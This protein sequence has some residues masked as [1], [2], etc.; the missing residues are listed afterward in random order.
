M[1]QFTWPHPGEIL[2]EEF[3]EP[4]GISQHAL[5]KAIGVSPHRINEIVHGKRSIT[6][7]TA[8]RLA[9]FFKT[10]AQIWINLQSEYDLRAAKEKAADVLTRIQ[11]FHFFAT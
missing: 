2:N 7:D 1:T 5:A 10:D 3:L 4:M 8:L 9:K 6:A 11:P